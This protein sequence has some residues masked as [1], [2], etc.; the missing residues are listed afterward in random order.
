MLDLSMASAEEV[1]AALDA[2]LTTRFEQERARMMALV[3][4][5][6]KSRLPP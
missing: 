5:G 3:R 1:E 6:G 4:G 2:I